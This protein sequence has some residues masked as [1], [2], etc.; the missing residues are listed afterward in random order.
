MARLIISVP[1]NR[2]RG[3]YFLAQQ[4]LRRDP[5]EDRGRPRDGLSSSKMFANKAAAAALGPRG[6]EAAPYYVPKLWKEA[7]ELTDP[8][9][10]PIGR[11]PGP[12]NFHHQLAPARERSRQT[13]V[14]LVKSVILRLPSGE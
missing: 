13:H 8:Q 7:N 3:C 2:R 9:R 1:S 6:S 4:V 14:Q 12:G 11:L 10:H 5:R